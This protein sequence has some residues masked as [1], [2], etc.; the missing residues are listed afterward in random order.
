MSIVSIEILR[1]VGIVTSATTIRY[2]T[3]DTF[4]PS[5]G[6]IWGYG[7]TATMRPAARG[8]DSTR[9]HDQRALRQSQRQSNIQSGR[10]SSAPSLPKPCHPLDVQRGAVQLGTWRADNACPLHVTGYQSGGCARCCAA[11]VRDYAACNHSEDTSS[12]PGP[13]FAAS[14]WQ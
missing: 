6:S 14:K 9:L 1:F 12:P 4:W 13:G 11:K 10:H 3:S 5:V 7:T 8:L 2:N